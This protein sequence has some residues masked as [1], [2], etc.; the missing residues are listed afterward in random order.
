[1]FKNAS[2]Q[3]F[4]LYIKQILKKSITKDNK[5]TVTLSPL[6]WEP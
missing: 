5:Q 4:D 1:M 3:L 6:I 2:I